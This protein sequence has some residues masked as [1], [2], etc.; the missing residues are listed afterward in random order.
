M[1]STSHKIGDISELAI[2]LALEL[3]GYTVLK[4]V[5]GRN[6]RFDLAIV[7]EAGTIFKVQCK[8]AHYKDGAIFAYT[9]SAH[10]A[11]NTVEGVQYGHRSYAGQVDYLAL[12]CIELEKSYLVPVDQCPAWAINLRVDPPK[13]NNAV[14]RYASGYELVPKELPPVV[15][16]RGG[17]RQDI[18]CRNCEKPT[19]RRAIYCSQD[20]FDALRPKKTTRQC[21]VCGEDTFNEVY[22][23]RRCSNHGRNADRRPTKEVL[24][25]EL[26]HGTYVSV[27]KKYGVTKRAVLQWAEKYGLTKKNL[28]SSD[29]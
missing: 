20:C 23:S 2:T 17:S 25:E 1:Q 22:C 16:T 7:D 12:Y 21:P 28:L 18:L 3:A 11:Y 15:N 14:V 8:T 5:V 9:C 29:E 10:Y 13:N 26:A 24:Q 27:G 6:L 19:P 4:P